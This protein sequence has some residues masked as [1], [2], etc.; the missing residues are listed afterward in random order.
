MPLLF[1]PRMMGPRVGEPEGFR[2][3]TKN[4]ASHGSAA[5]E[6]RTGAL[7][8]GDG[9]GGGGG[10]GGVDDAIAVVVGVVVEGGV[11]L[12]HADPQYSTVWSSQQS[13]VSLLQKLQLQ[14]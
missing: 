11:A 1:A 9:G 5:P 13:P 12:L 4:R 14:S 2:Y 3:S 8:G 10:G 7:E 6:G